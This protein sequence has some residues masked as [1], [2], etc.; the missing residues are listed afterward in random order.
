M[1][2]LVKA[3]EEVAMM[4]CLRGKNLFS[5]IK[6]RHC[7]HTYRFSSSSIKS[8][9]R[10]VQ[11]GT[12][13]APEAEKLL[14]HQLGLSTSTSMNTSSDED[15]L[16]S[17]ANLDHTRAT[18]TGFP[19]AVFAAGK[20]PKQVAAILDDMAKH[21]NESILESEEKENKNVASNAILAT[22]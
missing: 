7:V 21:V 8:I 12:L 4:L 15:A 2:S 18:R 22:R 10:S 6:I 5:K 16:E 9:L 17:F 20:T 11:N 3:T 13:A 14:V 1:K 19:E